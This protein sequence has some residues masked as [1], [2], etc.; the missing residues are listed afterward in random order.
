MT[1]R[2]ESLLDTLFASVPEGDR[3]IRFEN[4]VLSHAPVA[5]AV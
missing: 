4:Y 3:R 5:D 2:F 1:E